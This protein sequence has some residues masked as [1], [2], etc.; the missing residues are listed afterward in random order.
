MFCLCVWFS[1]STSSA[2]WAVRLKFLTLPLSVTHC[3]DDGDINLVLCSLSI[4]LSLSTAYR[5]SSRKHLTLWCTSSDSIVYFFCCLVLAIF[6][7]ILNT[8]YFVSCLLL[9]LL[10][11]NHFATTRDFLTSR[12]WSAGPG[13][14]VPVGLI[15]RHCSLHN[16]LRLFALDWWSWMLTHSDND[17]S[18]VRHQWGKC[19]RLGFQGDTQKSLCGRI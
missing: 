5:G 12:V 4:L 14:F 15:S 18:A 10:S 6:C 7:C 17:L 16:D 8:F 1:F 3:G 19:K 9:H 13:H 11:M 2:H